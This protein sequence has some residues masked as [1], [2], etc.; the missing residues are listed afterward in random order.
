MKTSVQI[1][2]YLR[3]KEKLRKFKFETPKLKACQLKT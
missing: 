2:K 1:S 3:L